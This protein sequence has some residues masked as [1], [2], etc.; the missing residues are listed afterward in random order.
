MLSVMPR[1]SYRRN[2]YRRRQLLQDELLHKYPLPRLGRADLKVLAIIAYFPP[3]IAREAAMPEPRACP[4]HQG[5]SAMTGT[6]FCWRL[7][8]P[9]WGKTHPGTSSSLW[10][11]AQLLPPSRRSPGLM[12]AEPRG[13]TATTTPPSCPRAAA[14]LRQGQMPPRVGG[15]TSCHLRRLRRWLH[16]AQRAETDKAHGS[17]R[18]LAHGCV[19]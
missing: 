18:A 12:P 15:D 1:K 14:P 2:I 16:L 19:F 4:D 8:P 17:T 7:L 13:I 11:R 10:G 9:G 3:I 5:T 6:R